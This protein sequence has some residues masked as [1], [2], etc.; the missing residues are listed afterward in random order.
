MKGMFMSLLMILFFNNIFS[1]TIG[2]KN[3]IGI[4]VPL[5]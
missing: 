3:R 1:Q 4:S 5:V 2:P